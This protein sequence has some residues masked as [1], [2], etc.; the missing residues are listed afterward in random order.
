MYDS[1]W[2]FVSWFLLLHGGQSEVGL[3]LISLR[4]SELLSI[5]EWKPW[6]VTG[7]FDP[8]P[9]AHRPKIAGDDFMGTKNRKNQKMKRFAQSC[10]QS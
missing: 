6:Q 7:T 5:P 1:A 3:L 9:L 8:S 4:R 10:H 2:R